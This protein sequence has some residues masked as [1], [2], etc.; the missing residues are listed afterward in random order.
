MIYRYA[1]SSDDAERDAAVKVLEEHGCDAVST[2][3]GS[4]LSLD[5]VVAG[6]SDADTVVLPSLLLLAPDACGVLDALARIECT[7]ATFMALEEGMEAAL[8]NPFFSHMGA[9]SKVASRARS[10]TI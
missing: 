1:R 6:A 9:L 2:D 10:R 5:E 4:R 8:D 7:G 3:A